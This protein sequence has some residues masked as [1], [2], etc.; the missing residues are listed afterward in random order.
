MAITTILTPVDTAKNIIIN[1]P[2]L[3]SKRNTTN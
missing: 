2:R 1:L 3:L